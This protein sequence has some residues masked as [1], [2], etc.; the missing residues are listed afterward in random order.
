MTLSKLV[1]SNQLLTNFDWQFLF[2]SPLWKKDRNPYKKIDVVLSF[3]ICGS[4][5]SIPQ[6]SKAIFQTELKGFFPFY[7]LF[8]L[9]VFSV[10][11]NF[12]LIFFPFINYLSFPHL[13]CFSLWLLFLLD[14][15]FF[16][17]LVFVPSFST[18]PPF[19]RKCFLSIAS[20]FAKLEEINGE[21]ISRNESLVKIK[22]PNQ[23]R[24]CADNSRW[25]TNANKAI[26]SAFKIYP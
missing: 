15:S 8:L 5:P 13:H 12:A 23:Y 4:S 6:L 21:N 25:S 14:F 7:C 11:F 17:T 2:P 19:E 26:N 16:Q 9:A 22:P 10:P 1:L 20:N 3:A 24:T 18:F